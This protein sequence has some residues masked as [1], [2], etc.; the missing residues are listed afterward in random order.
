MAV[1][2]ETLTQDGLIYTLMKGIAEQE[3]KCNG[4][5]KADRA[6]VLTLSRKK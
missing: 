3:G 4:S 5:W 6:Y 1:S 2:Y